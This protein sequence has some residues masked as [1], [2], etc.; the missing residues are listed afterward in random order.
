M[1]S[2]PT[3]LARVREALA[4]LIRRLYEQDTDKRS[5]NPDCDG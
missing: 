1:L 5:C 4:E 3:S 2:A